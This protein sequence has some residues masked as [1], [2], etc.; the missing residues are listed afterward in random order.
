[1]VVPTFHIIVSDVVKL[2]EVDFKKAYMLLNKGRF[3]TRILHASTNENVHGVYCPVV[4][5][6]DVVPYE[7]DD[8]SAAWVTHP[9]F[10]N[11]R[12]IYDGKKVVTL[13]L[14]DV[15]CQFFPV[16]YYCILESQFS[17]ANPSVRI[18]SRVTN[19]HAE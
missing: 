14:S 15:F 8:P 11:V 12:R 2:N 16:F 5:P 7:Q 18:A 4:N 10:G 9:T 13:R 1:M 19:S 6:F 17:N 3:F